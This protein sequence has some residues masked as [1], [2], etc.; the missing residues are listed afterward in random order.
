MYSSSP[1]AGVAFVLIG[2]LVLS[3]AVL[4]ADGKI[5]WQLPF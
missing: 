4:T 3:L 2:A 5:H 1:R